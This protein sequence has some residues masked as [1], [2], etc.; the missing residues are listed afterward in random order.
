MYASRCDKATASD[1]AT[2]S[3]SSIRYQIPSRTHTLALAPSLALSLALSPARQ[4]APP[5]PVVTPAEAL[6]A[7]ALL[8]KGA[9]LEWMC[10]L[11]VAM[12]DGCACA[13]RVGALT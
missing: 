6:V 13:G 8:A 5:P 10:R 4:E 3:S 11:V 1:T 12:V 9:A 7:E 2:T